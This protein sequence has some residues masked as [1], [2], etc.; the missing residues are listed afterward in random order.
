M[1]AASN[2]YIHR[3]V[4][5]Y[6]SFVVRSYCTVRFRIIHQRF[7][8]E[9]GQYLPARGTC[10]D[11]GCGFG[12]FSLY[13]AATNPELRIRGFDLNA[14][15]IETARATA[16][17]LRIDNVSYEHSNAIT[18]TYSGE[19]D[20]AYVIDVLHHIPASTVEPLLL[21]LCRIIRP[22]GRLVIKDVGTRPAYKRW[23]TLALDK[24]MD[25]R[26]SVNYWPVSDLIALLARCGFSV[27]RHE[28]V[29]LLPYPHVLYICTRR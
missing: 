2:D 16:S 26:S 10:L 9:I 3:I 23:F 8:D 27:H 25:P 5:A 7:L 24:I 29:D 4:A 15:R 6:D 19:F 13:F 17:R 1:D 11:I 18:H 12:L 21:A 22:G 20:A 28:M 14:R